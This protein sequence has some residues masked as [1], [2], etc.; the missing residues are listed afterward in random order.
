MAKY[1]FRRVGSIVP[2]LLGVSIVVFLTIQLTPG[3]PVS[4]FLGPTATPEARQAL[5]EHLGLDKPLVVQ[6]FV[7]LGNL[8]RGDLGL[9]VARQTDASVGLGRVEEYTSPYIVCDDAGASPRCR[10]RINRSS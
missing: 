5:T 9:S 7:W 8:L 10:P 1:L 2:I 4:A 3:D 6:Y